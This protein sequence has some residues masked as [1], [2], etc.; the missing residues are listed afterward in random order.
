VAFA[1]IGGS[2]Q[3]LWRLQLVSPHKIMQRYFFAAHV[4]TGLVVMVLA[5]PAAIRARAVPDIV[6][7]TCAF[8]FVAP[9]IKG[10][11]NMPNP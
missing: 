3:S 4:C 2:V 10:Q 6:G 11:N 8:N 1:G 9:K 5:K 7:N